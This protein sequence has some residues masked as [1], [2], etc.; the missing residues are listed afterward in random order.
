MRRQLRSKERRL[1]QLP[2]Y[3]Y[4]R[5]ETVADVD[6][7]LARFFA[8]KAAHFASQGVTNVFDEPGVGRFLRAASHTG[9]AD[10]RPLVELHVIEAEG[11]MLALFAGPNDGRRFSCLFNTYTLGAHARLSPGLVLLQQVTSALRTRQV[12]S[13]DLGIGYSRYKTTFCRDEEALVDCFVPV[14]ALGFA[15]TLAARLV[16]AGKR[17]IKRAPS[18][19]AAAQRLRRRLFGKAPAPKA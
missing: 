6:R 5:A 2:G 9:L 4:A 3:R 16:T 1:A 11:E 12:A 7:Y 17:R 18:V 10:G 19:Y 14:T 8:L 15:A 13:F